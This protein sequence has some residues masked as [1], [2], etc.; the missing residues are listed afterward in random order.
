V[1]PQPIPIFRDTREEHGRTEIHA[2]PSSRMR[3]AVPPE[4]DLGEA[5]PDGFGAFAALGDVDHDA[6]AF[7][8]VH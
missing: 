6:L 8:E 2:L 7:V 5:D 3:A 4:P 1:T